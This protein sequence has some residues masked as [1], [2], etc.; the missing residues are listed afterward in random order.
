MSVA[1]AAALPR[2]GSDYVWIELREPARE[3]MDEISRHFGLHELAVEDASRAHQRPKVESYDDFYFI[4][5][6][7]ASCPVGGTVSFGE[8]HLFL[9]AGYVIAVRHGDAGDPA[10]ARQRL[11]QRPQLVKSGPAAVV[12]AILDAVVDDYGPVAE[13]VERQIEE[14]EHA[15]F[16]RHEN[17]TERIYDLKSQINEIYRAAHPLLAPLDALERGEYEEID[18]GLRRYFRDTGDHVRR[19]QDEVLAQRDQLVSALEA[20]LALLSVQQ[21][22]ITAQQNQIVKQLTIVATVFLP[23]TFVTGFFGQNFGWLVRHIYSLTMFL[24]AGV[25]GLLVPCVL[26]YLWFRRSG[27]IAQRGPQAGAG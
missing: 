22:Q 1:A 4:V 17:L 12:W 8:L 3:L 15:I 13:E 14:V 2:R 20:N 26:L 7:T 9:G 19:V 24:V 27:L 21:S 25:G 11:E 18:P 10:S 6:R 16:A 5:Y 23:L